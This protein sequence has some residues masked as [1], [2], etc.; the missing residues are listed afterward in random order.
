MS[1][2]QALAQLESA[3]EALTAGDGPLATDDVALSD[4]SA[5]LR[6]V[7]ERVAAVRLRLLAR[8]ED[9]GTWALDGSRSFAH[10]LSRTEDVALA[11]ARREART[12]R[13]LQDVLP[14]SAAAARQGDLGSDHLRVMVDV[15][16]TSTARR[17]AL[18]A[19]VAGLAPGELE[20]GSTDPDAAADVEA[21]PAARTPPTGE[22]YLLGLAARYPV[23]AFRRLVRRFAHVA[24]PE[25]DERGY[26]RAR[27]KEFFEVSPTWDGYHVAGFLTEEHGQALR[28]A[29]DG[30]VGA[31]AA[32]DTRT[33]TQ[34]RA[35]GI[36]D[37]A[38]TVLD[39][40]A[41]GGGAAVRPHLS[42]MV[43]YGELHDL[44]SGPA[45]VDSTSGTAAPPPSRRLDDRRVDARRVVDE[46]GVATFADGRGPVPASVLRRLACDGEISRIVFGPDGAA[47]DV[48]RRRRTVTGQLR[49][50][51]IARD[52]RCTWPG[53][54][55]PPSRCE[56][57]HAVTHWADGGRTS[58]D[59]AA[60]LCWH[61]HEH[62]DGR[63]ISMRWRSGRWDFT[64]R[65]G[66]PVGRAADV[67]AGGQVGS[68]TG[69]AA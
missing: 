18:A 32:D 45:T 27:E 62:V 63:G 24:D 39:H 61:H 56:V 54:S 11:T 26:A 37:L 16:P 67:R 6:A 34:R 31:P 49:R 12:A 53:C 20:P 68:Q 41:V 52:R 50:A 4:L 28:A 19:P 15:A 46:T 48:G 29:L 44:L 22:Q 23:G 14:V 47:L 1:P 59:N 65:S 43:S 5:R 38:R 55:E 69:A 8:L 40:G 25:S 64:D 60:L 17:E 33:S 2:H 35:Q 30:V 51:V 21:G 36:A 7:Q 10:W 57:H 58:V 42:V 3:V 66:R 9:E 13:T